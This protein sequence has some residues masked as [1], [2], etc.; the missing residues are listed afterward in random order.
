MDTLVGLDF[1]PLSSFSPRTVYD[2]ITDSYSLYP[3]LSASI[4]KRSNLDEHIYSSGLS[5]IQGFIAA[6]RGEPV[7]VVL[8][9]TNEENNKARLIECSI[10]SSYQKKGY[11]TIM[12]GEAINRIASLGIASIEARVYQRLGAASRLLDRHNFSFVSIS[13]D[14]DLSLGLGALVNYLHIIGKKLPRPKKQ[15]K[16]WKML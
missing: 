14:S 12:L 1:L 3:T 9:E 10:R 8:W 15:R 13:R 5:N 16:K 11:G 4:D 2:I 6:L 7:G